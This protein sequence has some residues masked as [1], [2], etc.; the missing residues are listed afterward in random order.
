MADKI[1]INSGAAVSMNTEVGLLTLEGHNAITKITDAQ[2]K[3]LK[4]RKDFIKW[5]EKGYITVDVKLN[6][7][8]D[9][10]D[11]AN[12]ADINKQN[13]EAAKIR[14]EALTDAI[15]ANEGVT[16]REAATEEARKRLSEE[17]DK[18]AQ[19]GD[20]DAKELKAAS[21]AKNK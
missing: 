21:K 4:K 6:N 15:M 10:K 20:K 9:I 1:L 17:A 5:V 16:D 2:L 12:E 3:A 19:A 14:L 11:A 13:E 7:V 18:A 8:N